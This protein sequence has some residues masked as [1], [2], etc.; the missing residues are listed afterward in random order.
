MR[1]WLTKESG[2]VPARCDKRECAVCSENA[3]VEAQELRRP[4]MVFVVRAR[5]AVFAHTIIAKLELVTVDVVLRRLVP[6]CGSREAIARLTS[7]LSH[8]LWSSGP[9]CGCSVSAGMCSDCSRVS[10]VPGR[11]RFACGEKFDSVYPKGKDHWFAGVTDALEMAGQRWLPAQIGCL[12]TPSCAV[13]DM[14][15]WRQAVA[16]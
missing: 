1:G 4:Y 6:L 5:R 11:R 10:T 8:G 7:Q 12:Q 16:D 3:L 2:R 15:W 9:D 14:H 13:G